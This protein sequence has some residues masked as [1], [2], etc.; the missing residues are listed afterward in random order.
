[1]KHFPLWW[2]IHT[3]EE[4]RR[5]K[6]EISKCGI[7]EPIKVSKIGG[8]IIDGNLRYEIA[9]ELGIEVP[10]TYASVSDWFYLA[11]LNTKRLL[12]VLYLK[13]KKSTGSSR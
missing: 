7:K 1:M 6:K 2:V 12:R 4:R 11:F 10:F 5:L 3:D 9:R 13:V 8:I